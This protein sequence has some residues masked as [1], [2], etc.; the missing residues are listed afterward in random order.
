[1][2]YCT[3]LCCGI[4]IKNYADIQHINIVTIYLLVSQDI[5]CGQQI[6][7]YRL[8]T[9]DNNLQIQLILDPKIVGG[10]AVIKYCQLKVLNWVSVC[11]ENKCLLKQFPLYNNCTHQEW[12]SISIECPLVIIKPGTVYCSTADQL[13][14][15]INAVI[16]IYPFTK[17]ALLGLFVDKI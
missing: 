10:Q 1:M 2:H 4:T 12:V 11:I 17:M 6:T 16:P 9:T 15:C 13:S 8:W 5:Y 14:A 3:D 7:T